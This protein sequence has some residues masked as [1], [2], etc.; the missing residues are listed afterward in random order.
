MV[1]R[2]IRLREAYQQAYE[3]GEGLLKALRE[4]V[5]PAVIDRVEELVN[6]REEAVHQAASLFQ[7]GDQVLFQEQLQA[8]TRQQQTLDAEMR[9]FVDELAR[10][11]RG[12]AQ[13][14]STVRGARQMMSPGRRGQM[15]DEKR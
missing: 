13:V 11:A 1:D 8:L 10:V 5:T 14:K 4:P 7:P 15:L 2:H 6:R 3:A 12:A 9:R